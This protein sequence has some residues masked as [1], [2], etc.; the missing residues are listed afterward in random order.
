[1]HVWLAEV[2]MRFQVYRYANALRT[3]MYA[4]VQKIYLY[5]FFEFQLAQ[6]S[7]S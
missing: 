5:Q 4:N 6:K 7:H 2:D 3:H 1:M